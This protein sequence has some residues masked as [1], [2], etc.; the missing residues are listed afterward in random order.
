MI[1][2]RSLKAPS[3]TVLNKR[4]AKASRN[5]S[6]SEALRNLKTFNLNE[7]SGH[8]KVLVSNMKQMN[9][10][11]PLIVPNKKKSIKN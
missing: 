4:D 11:T 6:C 3:K 9:R 8:F 5:T 2:T 10:K 7:F 1:D